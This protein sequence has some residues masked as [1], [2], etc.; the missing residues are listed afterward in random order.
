MSDSTGSVSRLVIIRIVGGRLS[1]HS[2]PLLRARSSSLTLL[3][4][5]GTPLS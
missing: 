3:L 1:W 5:D 4:R 2:A